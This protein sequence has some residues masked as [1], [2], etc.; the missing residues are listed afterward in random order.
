V[1]IDLLKR[2]VEPPPFVPTDPKTGRPYPPAPPPDR[3]GERPPDKKP[4][5]D[6]SEPHDPDHIPI[7]EGPGFDPPA[8]GESG[9]ADEE[10]SGPRVE[11]G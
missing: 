10:D 2:A 11:I 9:S 7:F 1:D 8:P 3:A 6:E 5:A 4:T